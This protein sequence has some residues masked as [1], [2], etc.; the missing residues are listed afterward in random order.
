MLT[1][2]HISDVHLPPLPPMTLRQVANKRVLGYLSWHRE[3]KHEHRIEVLD[4]L[5]ADLEAQAPDHV[6]VTGDQTNLALPEEYAAVARWLP[7]LGAPRDV[8]V[9]PGNH[10]AYVDMDPAQTTDL[11]APWMRGDDGA[12]GFPFVRRRGHVSLIGVSTAIPTQP[13]MASGRI[14]KGQAARLRELLRDE[15]TEGRCRV[16]LIHHPPQP[17]TTVWRKGLHDARRLRAVLAAEGAEL[18]LHGHNHVRMAGYLPGVRGNVPVYGTAAA[19]AMGLGRRDP[20]QYHVIDLRQTASGFDIAVRSRVF[21]RKSG[22][23]FPE[24]GAAPTRLAD[25]GPD[26]VG[27]GV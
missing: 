10:D 7:R 12:D 1:L 17:G 24:T 14:G 25:P 9:I 6:C 3:R 13:L 22:R 19:S 23:F 4:A 16:L 5:V 18:V 11:W 26:L 2:A 8:T 21:D 27:A 20:A 15:G